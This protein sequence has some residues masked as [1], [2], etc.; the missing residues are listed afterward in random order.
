MLCC[1]GRYYI[2]GARARAL[3]SP[4]SANYA[5]CILA[6]GASVTRSDALLER[7]NIYIIH[8]R[9]F[10]DAEEIYIMRERVWLIASRLARL[11]R[12]IKVAS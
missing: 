4:R 6:H 8:A 11:R 5:R 9:S 12:E 10:F 3:V 1:A 2:P 7:K